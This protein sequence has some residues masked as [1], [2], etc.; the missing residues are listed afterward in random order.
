VRTGDRPMHTRA[1]IDRLTS[2]HTG[3]SREA[4]PPADSLAT[5]DRDVIELAHVAAPTV[6]TDRHL[7]GEDRREYAASW[8]P[9]DDSVLTHFSSWFRDDGWAGCSGEA[10]SGP[11]ARNKRTMIKL[12][13]T[14][15]GLR[16]EP[17]RRFDLASVGM[18]RGGRTARPPR[19]CSLYPERVGG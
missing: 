10:H 17:N 15:A 11:Q 16:M 5:V 4:G 1:S 13:Q 2:Q 14:Q 3:A 8:A 9:I 12:R 18:S 19:A 6:H 7:E